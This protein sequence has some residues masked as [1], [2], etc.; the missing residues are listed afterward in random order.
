M[1]YKHVGNALYIIVIYVYRYCILNLLSLFQKEKHFLKAIKINT[2][3]TYFFIDL[4]TYQWYQDT[5]FAAIN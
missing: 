5:E 2:T 3:S 4:P 1:I